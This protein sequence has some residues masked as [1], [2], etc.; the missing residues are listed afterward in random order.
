MRVVA[1]IMPGEMCMSVNGAGSQ[2]IEQI[3]KEIENKK[4]SLH[5]LSK[6]STVAPSTIYDVLENKGSPRLSTIQCICKALDLNI[7]AYKIDYTEQDDLLETISNLSE[8]K[9]ETVKEIV[10]L[11]DQYN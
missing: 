5:T 3:K 8:K 7:K 9:R 6:M 11:L 2:I 10:M 4:I 1:L